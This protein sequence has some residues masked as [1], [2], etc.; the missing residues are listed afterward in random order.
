MRTTLTLDED[1]AVQLNR[2]RKKSNSSLKRIVNDLLRLGLQQAEMP[3]RER[4]PYR[5][6]GIA[7]GRCLVGSIDDVSEAL[8][9]AEG[10][11]FR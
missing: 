8:A 4:K 11:S 2:L 7:L 10:E 6:E 3:D 5:T 1:V 9:V